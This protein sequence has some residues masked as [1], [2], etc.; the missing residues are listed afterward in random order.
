MNPILKKILL[1]SVPLLLIILVV[2]KLKSNK[3]VVKKKVYQLDKS[4]PINVEVITITKEMINQKSTFSG[5]FEPFKE[6]KISA[7][8]P[9]KINQILVDNGSVVQQGQVIV[10]LDNALLKLQLK[11]VQVQIEGLEADVKRFTILSKADA[12]QGIQLEK[13]ILG[14]RSAQIQKSLIE[15]QI[16]KSVIKAPFAGIITAKLTEVGAYA[17][18]GIP[19][20]QITDIY[21]LKFTLNI[22]ESDIKEFIVGKNVDVSVDVFPELNM[23]SKVLSVGSKANSGNSFPIQI[24]VKNSSNLKIKSGMFGKVVASNVSTNAGILIPNT[25]IIGDA[26]NPQVYLIKNGKAVLHSITISTKIENQSVVVK[27]LEN[28]DVIVKSGF[29][30]LYDGAVVAVK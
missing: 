6:T 21:N 26:S 30:N 20:L 29:I 14:L 11:S 9:G 25:T 17:A 22:P 12:I 18:P 2:V 10:L 1:V 15:E 28:G 5:T 8:V 27:G 19:L 13:A 7:E 4:I 23:K 16:N 3:E 24:L